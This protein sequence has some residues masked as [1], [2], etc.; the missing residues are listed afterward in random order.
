R[1]HGCLQ[2]MLAIA[3]FLG[4]QDPRERPADQRAAADNAHAL[5]ADPKS[6]FVGI[7]KLWEAYREAHEE[8]TQAQL[9][10]W[11]EKHFL[12]FLRMREWRE[13]HRQLKLQTGELWAEQAG[14]RPARRRGRAARAEAKPGS[15]STLPGVPAD[16]AP[17]RGKTDSDPG[18]SAPGE[19]ARRYALLHRALIAG[20]P[21]Q[22]GHLGERGVYE[23]PRGRRFQLFPGSA[24]ARKPP[25]WVLSA[26]LLDTEKVWAISNAAIEPD[27]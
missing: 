19:L 15:E 10:K 8:L 5:F 17:D 6:E 3:S 27:W 4:I 16:G 1:H 20:L 11:C 24:L 26:M 25:P 14:A 13:L 18:S 9:R 22:I 2:E 21:T 23:G 12:G 7:L